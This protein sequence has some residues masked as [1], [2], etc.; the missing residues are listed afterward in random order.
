MGAAVGIVASLAAPVVGQLVGGITQNILGSGGTGGAGE[1]GGPFGNILSSFTSAFSSLLGKATQ[2]PLGMLVAPIPTLFSPGSMSAQ[3]FNDPMSQLQ[4]AMDRF[5]DIAYNSN[6]RDHRG[7]SGGVTVRDHRTGVFVPPPAPRSSQSDDSLLDQLDAEM[8]Q[9]KQETLR[10]PKS[11][12]KA[13]RAAEAAQA[14]QTTANLIF[15]Q[16]SIRAS[17]KS[18]A[19]Q[20]MRVS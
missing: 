11:T 20:G 10:D 18:A 3:S 4:P 5:Q 16:N 17:L 15:A 9:T 8:E 12:S 2:N 14:L 13:N 6:V 7:S 1:A 19:I